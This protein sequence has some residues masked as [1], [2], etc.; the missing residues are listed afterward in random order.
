MSHNLKKKKKIPMACPC[1]QVKPHDSQVCY[2][3]SHERRHHTTERLKR[4]A[5]FG[6]SVSSFQSPSLSNISV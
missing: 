5:L 6:L 3:A 4:S 1:F 2:G